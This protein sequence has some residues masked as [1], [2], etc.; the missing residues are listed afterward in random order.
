MHGPKLVLIWVLCTLSLQSCLICMYLTIFFT[1]IN[2]ARLTINSSVSGKSTIT[3]T[4]KSALPRNPKVPLAPPRSGLT[5]NGPG[6]DPLEASPV[7]LLGPAGGRMRRWQKGGRL[8][9][10]SQGKRTDQPDVVTRAQRRRD[11][12]ELRLD[13]LG[14]RHAFLEVVMSLKIVIARVR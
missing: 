4:K 5:L 10:S 9:D 6:G 1:E 2:Q 11:A 7:D 14:L 8:V 13:R 12:S 3:R